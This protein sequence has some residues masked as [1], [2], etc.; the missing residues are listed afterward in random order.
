M[1]VLSYRLVRIERERK[2]LLKSVRRK[3]ERGEQYFFLLECL[4]LCKG[5]SS[6]G[7][8][9]KRKKKKKNGLWYFG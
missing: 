2:S 5:K 9:R 3:R 7:E 8:K 4:C 6:V 1:E